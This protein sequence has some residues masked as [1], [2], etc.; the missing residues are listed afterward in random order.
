MQI[1]SNIKNIINHFGKVTNYKLPEAA[2]FISHISVTTRNFT[3]LI[4]IEITIMLCIAMSKIYYNLI[5]ILYHNL[6]A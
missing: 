5:I 1:L 3:T 6:A 2:T 4:Y